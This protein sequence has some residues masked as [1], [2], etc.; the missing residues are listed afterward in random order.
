MLER[1]LVVHLEL[2]F[3]ITRPFHATGAVR[4]T[5]V[6]AMTDRDEARLTAHA[7]RDGLA[8]TVAAHDTVNAFGIGHRDSMHTPLG[9]VCDPF[10]ASPSEAP[11]LDDASLPEPSMTGSDLRSEA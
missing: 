9:G 6:V 11:N 2:L 4:T 3:T 1:G 7:K 5:T 10:G 8:R